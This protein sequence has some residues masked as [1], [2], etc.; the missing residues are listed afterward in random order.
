[1]RKL[2]MGIIGLGLAFERLHYPAFQELG[3][4]YEIAALCDTKV[5]KARFWA[6][7]L[8]LT[9]DRVYQD[10]RELIARDDLDAV[11]IMVPIDQNY[12]ITETVARAWAGKGRAILCEKPLAPTLEQA[13]AAAELPRLYNIPIMIAENYRYEEEINKLREL[14]RTERAGKAVYFIHNYVSGFPVDMRR[15]TFA[16]VEWRQHP[17]YPGGDILDAG[18]HPLAGL[19]HIFGAIRT[20]H[21]VGRRQDEDFAPF[22]VVNVNIKFWSGLNGQFAFYSAGQEPQRPLVGLRI[23]CTRG[24]IYHEERD[25]GVI[26]VAHNDG[27]AEQIPYTP[28][29]GYYNELVNFHQAFLGLEPL[30]VTPEMELGDVKTVFAILQSIREEE[31]VRVDEGPAYTPVYAQPRVPAQ[32]ELQ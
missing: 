10:Y 28:G 5:E 23:F 20:V 29:R 19:R 30:A 11:D 27:G 15:D 18:V 4:R 17:D 8:G 21:A 16:A 32:P 7:R 25:C 26:N 9:R 13:I 6:D 22:A 14:V 12:E 31:V 3:E 24:E 1:M 2:R